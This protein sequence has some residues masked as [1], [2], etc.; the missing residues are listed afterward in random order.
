MRGQSF[1]GT[2]HKVPGGDPGA[3]ARADNPQGLDLELIPH[4]GPELLHPE[5]VKLAPVTDL[6]EEVRVILGIL[7][8][9][10]CQAQVQVQVG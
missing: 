5:V 3:P 10:D 1:T 6:G 8:H 2:T 9:I 4:V 7:K